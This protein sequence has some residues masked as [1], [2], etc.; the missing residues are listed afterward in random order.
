MR[1]FV[2]AEIP[3]GHKASIDRAI[4]RLRL[5]LPQARWTAADGR[6]VTLKFLGEVPDERLD[7]VVS[8]LRSSLVRYQPV[9]TRLTHIGGFPALRRA[10]VLW[11]GIDDHSRRLAHLAA[12]MEKFFG[13]AGFLVESRKL[14]PHITLARFKSPAAVDGLVEE[15]GPYEFDSEPIEIQEVVLLCSHLGPAGATYERLARVGAGPE[16][17]HS[18]PLPGH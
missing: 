10:R 5:E 16:G 2:A 9:T 14:R 18:R 6:H 15:C 12:R 3:E 13:R 17:L 1:M 11:L 4:E 7:E 8:I